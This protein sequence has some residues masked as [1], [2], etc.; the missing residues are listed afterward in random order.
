MRQ[1]KFRSFDEGMTVAPN[2]AEVRIT[3]ILSFFYAEAQVVKAIKGFEGVREVLIEGGGG[4]CHAG[5]FNE[6]VGK[7]F[8][9]GGRIQHRPVG[10]PLFQGNWATYGLP[11]RKSLSSHHPQ[12]ERL[13]AASQGVRQVKRDR[14][15]LAAEIATQREG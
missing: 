8:F 2:V 12:S 1:L 15:E 5:V 4:P 7:T 6:D 14:E 10:L 13:S 9:I 11:R 3:K